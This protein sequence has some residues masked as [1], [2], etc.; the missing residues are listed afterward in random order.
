M[1]VEQHDPGRTPQQQRRRAKR[2]P[3]QPYV[4]IELH[5]PVYL[6]ELAQQEAEACGLPRSHWIVALVG[7]RLTGAP[8]FCR[9]AELA[10]IQVR[11]DLRRLRNELTMLRQIAER[12]GT[13]HAT[14][15]IVRLDAF[16]AELRAE[17]EAIGAGFRGNLDYWGGGK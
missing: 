1:A 12:D 8:R 10:L 11:S 5:L 4:R 17:M 3:P 6:A 7:H 14:D 16:R 13:S 9:D 2:P 15:L